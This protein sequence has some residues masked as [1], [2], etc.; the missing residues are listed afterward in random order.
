MKP[1]IYIYID[2]GEQIRRDLEEM[3]DYWKMNLVETFTKRIREH[4][5][6]IK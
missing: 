1:K 6:L 2:F 4:E 5:A 3:G